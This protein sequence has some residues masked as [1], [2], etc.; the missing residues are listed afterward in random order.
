MKPST[1][2]RFISFY[3][4][5]KR[6]LFFDLLCAMLVSAVGLIFPMIIQR[7]TNEVFLLHDSALMQRL[8]L[9]YAAFLL[10]LYVIEA[11][12]QFY[13]TSYGHI[14]GAKMEADMRRN[15]FS[16]MERLSFSYY[17]K[18]DT[19]NLMS[20]LITDLFDVTELAHHGPEDVFISLGKLIGSFV[21]L[22]NIHVPTTLAL[23]LATVLMIFFTYKQ[24]K[25][26]QR[27]FMEN[28]RRIAEV[29]SIIQDSLSGIRTVQ[30]FSN[31]HIEEKKFQDGNLRFLESKKENYLVMGQFHSSIGFMQGMMYLSVLLVGGFSIIRGTMPASS[32]I[33]YILYIN[34]FLEPI[35]RLVNFTEQ[36]QRGMTGFQRMIEV[37]DINPE[38][39]NRPHAKDAGVLKGDI[40]FNNVTFNYEND[41][42]VLQNISIHIP[43][44]STV[45]LVGPSGAGKTTFCSLIPRFYD[46]AEGQVTIDGTDVRDMTLQSL[47]ENIGVVQQDVYI[48]NSTVRDNIAFGKPDASDEEIEKAAKQANIHQFIMSLP[49]GYDTEMGD[50]GVRFSGGQKQRISIA[51]V[52][53]KNPPILILD[54]ATSSLDNESEIFIQESLNTLSR[55]RTTLVIAHRLSTI[56]NADEILTLTEN[57][58]VERG[59]HAELLALDGLYAKLYRMQFTAL[60]AADEA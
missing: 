31:E 48:F 42:P 41:E 26:M 23:L 20:R 53:L 13:M 39:K 51:R 27:T 25:R 32:L 6:T 44:G 56:R 9:Q 29:N 47:R 28:R 7:L 30:S 19:G 14:M 49:N 21:I 46:V 40:R 37:L 18:T 11:L 17:D 45:A 1:F 2:K 8:L 43:Q 33:A 22:F 24:N 35:R 5:Y 50:R 60:Q 36:Y 4:P 10:I 38:V 59:S 57:G 12:A 55:D 54:E 52:F 58:I 15:L 16:H 3:G 34:M